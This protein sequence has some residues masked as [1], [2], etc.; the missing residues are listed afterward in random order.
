MISDYRKEIS[1]SYIS[2]LV[3]SVGQVAST[4]ITAR[5]IA[6]TE[7]G[8][9]ALVMF[10]CRFAGYFAQLGMS[11]ALI[12]KSE[13]SDR[14]VRAAFTAS[15]ALGLGAAIATAALAPLFARFFHE[16]R[17]LW[18]VVVFSINFVFQGSSLVSGGLLRRRLQM[19]QL[20]IADNASY[21]IAAFI[22]AV[23]LAIAGLG[24]WSVIIG[25]LAQSLITSLWYYA[26]A[27]H[28]IRPT[29]R[30]D[31]F[32]HVVGFGTKATA[33]SLVEAS[34][35][36]VDTFVL[37]R[38]TSATIL[39]LY[40]RAYM[41][42]M[43][44]VQ[45]FS[46]GI[47]RVLFTTLS[48]AAANDRDAGLRQ[49]REAQ[50]TMLAISFPLCLGAAAAGSAVVFT[51]FGSKWTGAV[52]IYQVLCLAAAASMSYRLPALYMEAIARFRHKTVIQ[53]LFLISFVAAAIL[54]VRFGVVAVAGSL[55]ALELCRSV[56]I[57][58]YCAKLAGTR[59]YGLLT[60]WVPGVQGGVL[61][62]V[63]LLAAR[64]VLA[65]FPAVVQFVICVALAAAVLFVFYRI[66]YNEAVV[67]PL[68]QLL[69]GTKT[70]TETPA[71]ELATSCD[72]V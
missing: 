16:P 69:L 47:T 64:H 9:V 15:M 54:L 65:S 61:V 52:H 24:A 53:T 71:A 1:W 42:I 17:L 55:A 32:G 27:P 51:M 21:V 72:S 62:G 37:G 68:R 66:F 38:F 25:L 23:P 22:I 67:L 41:L 35:S 8:V 48:Q 13:I 14:D 50:R 31:D 36:S 4:A 44:P 29:F 49:L 28:S 46:D 5:L 18:I 20:A 6:P 70:S 11:R 58:Y 33:V 40:S 39:G 7:F 60:T 43:L 10:C 12:Q 19:K 3:F 56:A 45:V 57:N 2:S 30:F 26:Y 34:G 59:G 63:S